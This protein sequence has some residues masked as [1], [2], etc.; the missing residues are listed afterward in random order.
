VPWGAVAP[1]RL[2]QRPAPSMRVTRDNVRL[3]RL[4]D[5]P[6]ASGESHVPWGAR[7]WWHERCEGEDQ[8]MGR[9]EPEASRTLR[10]GRIA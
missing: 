8:G 2:A 5:T 6:S 1:T 9:E 7:A 10:V 4:H 3:D